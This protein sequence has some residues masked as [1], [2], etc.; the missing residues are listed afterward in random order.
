MGRNGAQYIRCRIR[1]VG[2]RVLVSHPV[3]RSRAVE[4]VRLENLG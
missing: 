2:R 3:R 1:L 4:A